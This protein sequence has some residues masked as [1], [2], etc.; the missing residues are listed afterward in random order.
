MVKIALSLLGRDGCN[1]GVRNHFYASEA[2][3]I[4]N[5]SFIR[6]SFNDAVTGRSKVTVCPGRIMMLFLLV[7]GYSFL[8]STTALK[9]CEMKEES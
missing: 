1:V 7:S 2:H 3:H 5:D 8:E 4:L 6:T 9:P